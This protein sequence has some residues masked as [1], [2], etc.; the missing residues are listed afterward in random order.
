MHLHQFV[1][2][3]LSLAFSLTASSILS[4]NVHMPFLSDTG[5]FVATLPSVLEW[6]RSYITQMK[7]RKV[8]NVEQ[9]FGNSSVFFPFDLRDSC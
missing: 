5:S 8:L 9:P 3:H 7:H 4:F 6:E 2:L 1:K